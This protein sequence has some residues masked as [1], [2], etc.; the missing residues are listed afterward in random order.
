[1]KLFAWN[2]NIHF[3][4]EFY[5]N[6]DSLNIVTKTSHIVLECYLQI[7]FITQFDYD[8]AANM[9]GNLT[10]YQSM[11]VNKGFYIHVSNKGRSQ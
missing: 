10:P 4:F 1:M 11:S 5:N 9:F 6:H 3:D 8:K 2:I 7:L